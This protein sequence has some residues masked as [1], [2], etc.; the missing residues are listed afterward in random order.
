M[1]IKRRRFVQSLL[2]TPAAPVALAAVQA[3]PAAAPQQPQPVPQPNTPARQ[4][5]RQPQSVPRLP[6]IHPDVAA[7]T[8][9]HFFSTEQFAALQKLGNVL[10]PPIKGNPGALDTGAPE[11][12]DFLVSV[13][14]ADRQKLYQNGLDRLNALAKK[15]FHAPF[16]EL[17]ATQL[18]SILRPLLVVRYWPEDFP[19]DPLK[20]FLAQAHQ[21]FRTA[22]TNSREWAEATAKSGHRFTRG[23]NGQGMYWAPIDPISE[24]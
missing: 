15:Q 6:V 12:L 4:L 18:D 23:F 2:L 22:T 5:S 14:P 16:A 10:M 19:S 8:D 9:Q 3:T 21:D 11:F 24:G 7:K 17:N 20:N 13:S 1:S